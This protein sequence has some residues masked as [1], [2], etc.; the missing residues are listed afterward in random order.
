SANQPARVV[1]ELER[2]GIAGLFGHREVSGHHGYHKPDVRLFLRACEDLGVATEETIMVG[3]RVDNDVA[4]AKALGMKAVLF[5]TGRHIG[6]QPRSLDEA[7]DAE[8]WALSEVE[9]AILRL[10]GR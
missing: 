9:A 10:G 5:R 6:Q 7:P 1:V 3:D 4:P 2:H 8:A